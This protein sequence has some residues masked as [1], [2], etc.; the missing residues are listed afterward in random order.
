[1][2]ILGLLYANSLYASI[3]FESLSFAYNEVHLYI[4]HS[5]LEEDLKC[6]KSINYHNYNYILGTKVS[7]KTV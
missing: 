6:L 7:G 4:N 5:K 1:M 3:F 2:V